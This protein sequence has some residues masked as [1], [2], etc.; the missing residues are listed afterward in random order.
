M[1][2]GKFKNSKIIHFEAFRSDFIGWQKDVSNCGPFWTLGTIC[3]WGVLCAP[4]AMGLPMRAYEPAAFDQVSFSSD[5]VMLDFMI[6]RFFQYLSIV[7][8]L[9]LSVFPDIHC[10]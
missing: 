8:F 1:P 3:G 2:L 7:Y 4:L 6:H 5:S 9:K 10:T